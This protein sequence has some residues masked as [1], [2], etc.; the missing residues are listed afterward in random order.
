VVGGSSDFLGGTSSRRIGTV[1]FMF[2]TQL[3][4]L[5]LAGGWV[6]VSGDPMPGVATLAAAVGAGL[7]LLVGLA[8][9]FQAMVVGTVSIVAPISATGVVVPICAGIGGGERPGVAQAIGMAVAIVGIVLA[10][11]PHH[12]HQ[13]IRAESGIGLALVAAA[14][15]GLCLWLMGP[16]SRHGVSW[17]LL[18][19]RGTPFLLL[20]AILFHRR[21]TLR[22]AFE[23]RIAAGV[24]ASILLGFAAALALYAFATLHGQL[25]TVSVLA[26]LYPAVTVLLAY[27]VLRERLCRGQQ[28]GVAAVLAGVALLASR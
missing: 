21:M 28:I 25:A 14:G 5:V 24:L 12:G 3:G 20:V 17:A 8:A 27:G 26:S 1:Q 15:G 2:L 10:V 22:P 13:I 23:W 16:A 18:V 9:F 4:G 11:R 19:A 7:G 6:V